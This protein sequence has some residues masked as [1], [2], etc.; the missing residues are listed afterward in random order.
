MLCLRELRG[1]RQV[2]GEVEGQGQ[3][4]V[5]VSWEV[6]VCCEEVGS[7]GGEVRGEG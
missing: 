1:G 6:R 5:K 3:G 2:E 7:E 4:R